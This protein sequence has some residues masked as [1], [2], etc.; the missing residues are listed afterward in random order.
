M[1]QPE[2]CPHILQDIIKKQALNIN[3]CDGCGERGIRTPGGVTHDGF[4]DRFIK[5]L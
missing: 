5:P 1:Q 3:T 2:V 4:Q